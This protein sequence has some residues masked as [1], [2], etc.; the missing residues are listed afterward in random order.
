MDIISVPIQSANSGSIIGL[1]KTD[2]EK[3]DLP[4]DTEQENDTDPSDGNHLSVLYIVDNVQSANWQ[5]PVPK[6]YFRVVTVDCNHKDFVQV[7][8]RRWDLFI[9]TNAAAQ[10]KVQP[11]MDPVRHYRWLQLDKDALG[12]SDDIIRQ[13]IIYRL[14]TALLT[15]QQLFV[16]CP[17]I[18]V[19]TTA[20]ESKHRINRP[21][22][23]LQCQT[24]QNWEWIV[25][26]DNYEEMSQLFRKEFQS[27]VQNDPRVRYVRSSFDHSGYIGEVKRMGFSLG[28][29]SW[30]IELDHDDE[31][32]PQLFEML[33][34]A[35][36]SN[37][38]VG[39]IY[40]DGIQIHENTE[41]PHSFG[42]YYGLGF[43][44]DYCTMFHAPDEKT[45]GH[46]HHVICTPPL[47]TRTLRHIIGVPNHVRAWKRTVYQEING[48]LTDLSVADDY[49][50]ILRTF[51][52]T[53]MLRLCMNGYSQYLNEGYNNFTNKRNGLIQY[54][55]SI[56]ACHYDTAITNRITSLAEETNQPVGEISDRGPSQ[57]SWAIP[58]Y[59]YPQLEYLYDP[60]DQDPG[61]PCFS[62]VMPTYNRH[63]HLI[64]ALRSVLSQTYQN[65]VVY[66][67]G[68]SCSQIATVM[69]LAKRD[70][71]DNLL[72]KVRWWN[73]ED[74]HGAGGAVPR[75]YALKMLV[76]TKWVA[77][78]DD[79]NEWEPNHLEVM[80]NHIRENK[81][82]QY[83]F[84]SLKII[85]KNIIDNSTNC[86][87]TSNI[88][89][90]YTYD[91]V[92]AEYPVRGQMDTS[93]VV[94]RHDLLRKYGL[95]K[96][97]ID[98]G[99][100]HDWELFSRWASEP[101]VATKQCT[102]LYS[103]E[104]NN[105]TAESIRSLGKHFGD[106]YLK[107]ERH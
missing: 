104:F 101:W 63:E 33:L 47:N 61:N 4:N 100:A 17:L 53:R 31:L 97:R 72:Q 2:L 34:K 20:F 36:S 23:S 60:L 29:G 99:Y 13:A 42:H 44:A 3:P 9:T 80:V 55:V 90:A 93:A 8:R 35:S 1:A 83:L 70:L 58:Y 77:Y 67:V 51:L 41:E 79:D 81:D 85:S 95:W 16:Q 106:E 64:K 78:L 24:Y 75:N 89:E 40:S 56:I 73:L 52:H 5:L 62:I 54:I 21:W 15:P 87:G 10:M 91:E 32:H 103:T 12:Q 92:I 102:V 27:I 49:E 7:L 19:I 28:Q 22:K 26:D 76:T 66:I 86:R 46:Y 88:H 37:P 18:S 11:Y 65:F 43:G 71:P 69:A 98:A 57:V 84:G 39:F 48:H 45:S 14:F 105:Q 94:H 74:N 6:D 59:R 25:V 38:D 107:Q 82:C 30:L 68:D 50:L 96:D